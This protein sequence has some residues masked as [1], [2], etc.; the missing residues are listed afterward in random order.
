VRSLDQVYTWDQTLSQGLVVDVDH[1]TLGPLR[2]PG[3]PLRF[4]DEAGAETTRTAHTPPPVLDADGAD[5]RAWL[6]GPP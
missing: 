5:I 2:L 6:A 4:F 1:A 3:P